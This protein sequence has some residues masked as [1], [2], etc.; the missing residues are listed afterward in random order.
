M[1]IKKEKK[2]KIGVCF[3]S[4][5]LSEG[6]HEDSDFKNLNFLSMI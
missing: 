5:C 4:C 6:S 1:K 2:K 3:F